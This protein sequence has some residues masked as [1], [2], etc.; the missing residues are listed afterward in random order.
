MESII[1]QLVDKL[2]EKYKTLVND[3][4]NGYPLKE[5]S[6]S[7]LWELMQLIDCVKSGELNYTEYIKSLRPYE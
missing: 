4:N 1:K 5:C 7:D 6:I 2:S 3:L